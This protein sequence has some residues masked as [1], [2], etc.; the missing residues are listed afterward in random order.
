[1][2]RRVAWAASAC[3]VLALPGCGS[4]DPNPALEATFR[5]G[6]DQIRSSAS[7]TTLRLKLRHTL[8]S[9]RGEQASSDADRR[10][11]RLAIAG[12]EQTLEGVKAQIEFIENDRGE[13]EAATEDAMRAGRHKERGADLLRAAGRALN[14]PVGRLA[15]Y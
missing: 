3:L 12:F 4:S 11:R 5:R 2:H 15:G 13:I 9:L 6:V 1:M 7:P 10:G 14:V 8:A